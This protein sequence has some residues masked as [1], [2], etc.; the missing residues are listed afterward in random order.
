MEA[1]SGLSDLRPPKDQPSASPFPPAPDAKKSESNLDDPLVPAVLL[2]EDNPTDVFVIKE[3]LGSCGVN[4]SLHIAKDG[5]EALRYFKELDRDEHT[6]CPALVLL[7]LNLPRVTGIEVLRELRKE[8]R[9]KRTPVVV[10]TSSAAGSDRV[11]A[12]ELGA[13]AYFQKPSDLTAYMEL[14]SLIKGILKRTEKP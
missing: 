1:E 10:I 2:V 4:L 14:G 6:V 13:E 7:D 12:H 11:A 3:V 5:Q 8:S 9:C